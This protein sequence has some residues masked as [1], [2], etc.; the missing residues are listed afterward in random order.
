VTGST[1]TSWEKLAQAHVGHRCVL[2]DSR[3]LE[4]VDCS[5]KLLLPKDATAATPIPEQFTRPERVGVPMPPNFRERVWADL[6]H[7]KQLRENGDPA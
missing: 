3:T 1:S 4:C 2:R 7:K 5:H 6:R